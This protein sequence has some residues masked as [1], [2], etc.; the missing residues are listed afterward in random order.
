MAKSM[1]ACAHVT[2]DTPQG[3]WLMDMR[4]VNNKYLDLYVRLPEE[5]RGFEAELRTK[6]QQ[7]VKRGKVEL[8]LSIN[9][10]QAQGMSLDSRVLQHYYDLFEQASQVVT[11]M[12]RPTLHDILTFASRQTEVLSTEEQT[13]YVEQLFA[14]GMQSFV[15]QRTREGDR[16]VQAMR[17]FSEELKSKVAQVEQHLPAQLVEFEER[18]YK[19]AQENLAPFVQQ[20]VVIQTEELN[21]RLALE[22]ASMAMK[23]NVEEEITRL[24]SHIQELEVL[25]SQDKPIGKRLDFLFQEM[26]REVNTLGSKSLSVEVNALVIDMK[27]I[28]DKLREQALNLE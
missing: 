14:K 4:S 2:L 13:D 20:G 27:V 8:R 19:K 26:N 15:E 10:T 18:L 23:L 6:V 12:R 21:A 5:L 1:T 17:E 16:L 7:Y 9:E 3:Q 25:L 24:K 11:D 22:L 28:V